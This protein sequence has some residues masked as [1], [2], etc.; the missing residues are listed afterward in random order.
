MQISAPQAVIDA[1]RAEID[2]MT[3]NL[4][5]GALSHLTVVAPPAADR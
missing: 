2:L 3:A 4:Q 5:I 1:H